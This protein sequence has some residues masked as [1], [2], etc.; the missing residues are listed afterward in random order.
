MNT[1]LGRSIASRTRGFTLIEL[2]VVIAI[3]AVLIALLLPAV[4]AAREAARRAQCTNN[5]KQIGLALHNYASTNT[6]FP[7][8]GTMSSTT[9]SSPTGSAWGSWSA[10]A[11]MLPYM[12][13]S[14]TYNSINFNYVCV[15]GGGFDGYQ[16]NTTGVSTTISSFQCP[17]A[18]AYPG[19]FNGRVSPWNNYFASV[20][21]S[22]NQ[23]GDVGCSKLCPLG[24][25]S[26]S[27][28]NGIFGV[29]GPC[30]STRDI[31]DGTSNTIAFGEWR[32][33]D[34]QTTKL[35]IPQ[36]VIWVGSPPAGATYGSALLNMP[37]GG[38]PF[39]TWLV[40]CAGAAA[41]S[42]SNGNN[43]SNLGQFWCESLFGDTV[44]NVLVAPNSNYPNCGYHQWGG[45]NDGSYGNYGLSSYHSGGA[46]I[47]LADGSVRFIKNTTN[48]I[49]LW[50]LGSRNQNEV[51][52]ASSF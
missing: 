25:P 14:T 51:I 36:D 52:D 20:G 43:W 18:P 48:Q 35:T 27:A 32:T 23:Y 45:E 12:E 4:Q 5:L 26:A 38:N 16:L 40:S 39:N 22:M 33:G 11:M 10:H 24:N 3:I 17:S 19:T 41:G 21:S 28:P 46:N 34:N 6:T 15:G 42:V 31:T 13:Q 9:E 49:T 30:L 1:P 2:L 50:G 29:G 47:L 37:L 8:G 44:G 7:P